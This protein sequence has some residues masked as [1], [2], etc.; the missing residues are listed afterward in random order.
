MLGCEACPHFAA[1]GHMLRSG[2]HLNLQDSS[3]TMHQKKISEKKFK[4]PQFTST[5]WTVDGVSYG[6]ILY[7]NPLHPQ[8]VAISTYRAVLAVW[9]S[10]SL[11]EQSHWFYLLISFF[12]QWR[13][14]FVLHPPFPSLYRCFCQSLRPESLFTTTTTTS[15]VVKISVSKA[16]FHSSPACFTRLFSRTCLVL[17]FFP[18][19]ALAPELPVC[20]F[21][22]CVSSP[23]LGG[24]GDHVGR[25][26][27]WPA[28][29]QRQVED[30]QVRLA[31]NPKDLLQE[32]QLLHQ[33][34]ARGGEH[35]EQCIEFISE[36]Y[37]SLQIFYKH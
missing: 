2:A 8:W 31:Q 7:W 33:N 6:T 14:H 1:S 9:T 34:P 10:S 5:Y 12:V 15:C 3:E 27:K 23:G 13:H 16:W 25:L 30:Q 37:T 28:H 35:S 19:C 21:L 22:V 18:C 17:I 26:C 24:C 4:V 36:L 11:L 29:L 20:H 32:E